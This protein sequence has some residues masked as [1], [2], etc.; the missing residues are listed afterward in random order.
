MRCQIAVK[1]LSNTYANAPT[2]FRKFGANSEIIDRETGVQSRPCG[3]FSS[4]KKALPIVYR[5]MSR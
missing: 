1:N 2:N 5:E 4:E 3:P